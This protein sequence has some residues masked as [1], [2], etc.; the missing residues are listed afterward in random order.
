[1]IILVDLG[2][3]ILLLCAAALLVV[4]GA[5]AVKEFI[6]KDNKK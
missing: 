6:K 1:M 3:G 2:I 4:V 5:Q